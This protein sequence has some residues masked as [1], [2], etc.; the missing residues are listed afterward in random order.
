MI[1]ESLEIGCYMTYKWGATAGANVWAA[2]Q[3][4]RQIGK[5][6]RIVTVVCDYVIK[7]LQGDLYE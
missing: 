6:K 4:A 5:G 7:Y 3:R 2:L 1:D